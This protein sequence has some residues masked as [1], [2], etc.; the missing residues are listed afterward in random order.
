MSLVTVAVHFN[1][2]FIENVRCICSLHEV[3]CEWTGVSVSLVTV[4]VHFNNIFIDN[5]RRIS[6]FSARDKNCPLHW[7]AVVE[8][9]NPDETK[10]GLYKQ[11]PASTNK[12]HTAFMCVG[13]S[14]IV[15]TEE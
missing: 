9:Q 3:E 15:I 13:L 1:N 5:I 12:C 4:A 2:I 8:V 6:A 7:P 14:V 10:F 11:V